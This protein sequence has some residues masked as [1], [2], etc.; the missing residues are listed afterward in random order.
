MSNKDFYKSSEYYK[1]LLKEREEIDKLK[2]I[3]SEK[4]GYDIGFPI[5]LSIWIKKHRH[6][7]LDEQDAVKKI[8]NKMSSLNK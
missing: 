4:V 7:W 5:A 3:E 1:L 8:R 6:I 2:W